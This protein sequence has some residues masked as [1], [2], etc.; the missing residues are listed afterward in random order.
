[1]DTD[2]Q[3]AGMLRAYGLVYEL[4]RNHVAV[5]WVIR[6]D[7]N[8]G[9]EDFTA[10]A[11]DVQTNTAVVDHG[12]RGG[13]WVIDAVDADEAMVVI[14]AWQATYPETAVHEV[15]EA[16]D[17]E[18]A[19]YLVV[20]PTIGMHADGNEGIARDYLLAAGIPDSLL[21]PTWPNTSP[22]MIEPEELAGPSDVDHADGALFDEDGDPVY[23]QFMSMHWGVGNA[24]AIPEAVA[25]VR[26][27]LNHPTHFFAECQAVS[28]FE[29][30]DPHGFFL[31][32]NGLLFADT[33]DAVDFYNHDSPYAQL[34]GEFETVGGSEPAYSLP[35]GDA[36]KAGGV[37]MMTAAGVPEGEQDVWMTGYL[38]GACPPDALECGSFGKVS[39][40]GGHQYSTDTPITAHPDSQG[41]RLFLNSLFE[42][43]CATLI[44]LP[45]VNLAAGAPELV[46]VPEVTFEI[47]YANAG[48]VTALA[49]TLVDP[50]PPDTTFV[51]ATNG[52]A[53]VGSDVV[54]DLGNL[55]PGEGGDVS[56]TVQLAD[57]GLYDNAVRLDYRIGLNAFTLDSNQTQTLYDPDGV[58][59]SSGSSDAAPDGS[60]GVGESAEA[61]GE[62][63]ATTSADATATNG[64]EDSGDG[65]SSAGETESS[66]CGCNQG[67]RSAL[68]WLC[69]VPLFVRRRRW[70][71]A[72]G[73]AACQGQPNE[74]ASGDTGSDGI[75]A[76][77]GIGEVADDGD[78]GPKLDFGVAPDLLT[79]FGCAKIDFLFV[80]DSSE[81]MTAHQKNLVDSFPG[82]VAAMQDA[83]D[84][85]DWHVMVVDTDAQWGGSACA[86]ACTTLGTC[87]D[88]PA[89]ACDTPPPELCDIVIGAGIVAPFGQAATNGV[90]EVGGDA[91]YIGP[92]AP[93]LLDSFT[94]VA[95][96]GVDGNSEER[97][98]D[99]VI[100]AIDP[101]A[102][103]AD[104][105]NSGFLRDDAILVVTI[106][107][108]EADAD[109]SGSPQEW[110][111]AI[112]A[113]KHDD[114]DAIV[115]LGLLPDADLDAPMCDDD[116]V[117]GVV[118][119]LV[120]SFPTGQRASVC[121]ADYGPFLADAVSVI[122]QTCNDFVPP[123]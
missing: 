5:R 101:A 108:D 83:V 14:T 33:P 32:P 110:H 1:M 102:S 40:L 37:V 70:L 121:E 81:S 77:T 43:P 116:D 111:D 57:P 15:T 25:E 54:W 13:P 91:R 3:D 118:A 69:L 47:A 22:D 65:S 39:Y 72:F 66:G 52:G 96:V 95:R 93:D 58:V 41:A 24:E 38:D 53:L 50:L 89:F 84:A 71:A 68:G 61:E 31:T 123:G 104:G 117:G 48:D 20:A 86:N 11:V 107:T 113:A 63:S 42:A 85:D 2:F 98:A 21:D 105:C 34:D 106:I 87:P 76:E 100:A 94:C 26:E 59:D 60:E 7:K 64:S 10:S 8:F 120:D 122:A 80:I 35:V 90:C 103:A 99:A 78:S 73:L 36:Y 55:G 74:A 19:R 92:A 17:A 16:F 114:P 6:T 27:F 18:V 45:I 51:S 49:A 82:F 88:E 44:G 75:G 23:C 46:L 119:E 79:E 67:R 109:S 97:T 4:L 29:N 62:T 28:A 115:V 30:L 12:Y 112:V 9:E 56:V